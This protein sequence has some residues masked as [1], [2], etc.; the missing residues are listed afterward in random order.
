[1]ETVLSSH[2]KKACIDIMALVAASIRNIEAQG[3]EQTLR[4]S[5]P[6]PTLHPSQEVEFVANVVDPEMPAAS[7][8][9]L[10]Q[11]T[12][13]VTAEAL[14]NSNADHTTKVVHYPEN[15]DTQKVPGE[16]VRYRILKR[17]DDGQARELHD[18]ELGEAGTSPRSENAGIA[19]SIHMYDVSAEG[20]HQVESQS[21]EEFIPFPD[22]CSGIVTLGIRG[23][24]D[25][26]EVRGEELQGIVRQETESEPNHE[27]YGAE[28]TRVGHE[29]PKW[30][31]TTKGKAG[32]KKKEKFRPSLPEQREE[33]NAYNQAEWGGRDEEK[34][35][36]EQQDA[37]RNRHT[38]KTQSEIVNHEVQVESAEGLL[39]GKARKA[40]LTNAQ[41]NRERKERN[42][43][44]RQREDD[45]EHGQAEDM[46]EEGEAKG[47][48]EQKKAEDEV[49]RQGNQEEGERITVRSRRQ[50]T[51][52]AKR[53]FGQMQVAEARRADLQDEQVEAINMGRRARRR[54]RRRAQRRRRELATEHGSKEED[55]TGKTERVEGIH[56]HE[57]LECGQ[58]TLSLESEQ[59]AELLE[60]Q[61]EGFEQVDGSH[62]TKT[63]NGEQGI[64]AQEPEQD[65]RPHCAQ[66][67]E[68]ERAEESLKI[69]AQDPG[70]DVASQG[71][72]AAAIDQDTSSLKPEIDEV[73]H[74]PETHEPQSGDD[75]QVDDSPEPKTTNDIDEFMHDPKP[76][77]PR[78][79][80]V[81]QKKES[82]ENQTQSTD[83]DTAFRI[84]PTAVI[85]QETSPQEPEPDDVVHDP[86]SHGSQPRD[87][88]Q[89]DGPPNLQT[90]DAE[91]DTPWQRNI[92]FTVDEDLPPQRTITFTFDEEARA[93]ENAMARP[94]NVDI[95]NWLSGLEDTRMR[96]GN[97]D[98]E[99]WLRALEDEEREHRDRVYNRGLWEWW[100]WG[101]HG[102]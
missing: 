2:L 27:L 64:A 41:R 90:R 72:D 94:T 100:L 79:R 98:I 51:P 63:L 62:E 16:A 89:I 44:R 78:P 56:E 11:F 85:A 43:L 30:R 45:F 93:R 9:G 61:K 37:P 75:A 59:N 29:R 58:E 46:H 38:E 57:T 36:E 80:D 97:V 81:E 84:P 54:R 102:M 34:M 22:R 10:P 1:M 92:T 49:R 101:F 15:A 69:M 42:R 60:T 31:K 35:N 24:G 65:A 88:E 47:A 71:I 8:E 13:Q 67:R 73:V 23:G 5:S 82:P 52:G 19:E 96:P 18:L 66:M 14:P 40:G 77:E 39:V 87:A 32:E 33:E 7:T 26:G 12:T 21:K 86:E 25:T 4:C 95:E 6:N 3:S 91:Q 53:V 28:M 76:H 48:E 17:A 68:V 50:S 74:D 83:L 70:E 99:N 20:V 55:D